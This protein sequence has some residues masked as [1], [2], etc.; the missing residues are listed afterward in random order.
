MDEITLLLI[1]ST[2]LLFYGLLA[3]RIDQ[4]GVSAP[5]L[6]TAVGILV[7]PLMLNLIDGSIDGEGLEYLSEL[8][9]AIILFTDAS[10]VN[11]HQLMKYGVLPIR[12]LAIGLPLTIVAGWL[13]AVPLLGLSWLAA[14]WLAVMLAPTDAALAQSI[15]SDRRISLKLRHTITVESGLNDGLALPVLLMILAL[16]SAGEYGFKSH[17]E[18]PLFMLQ[19]FVVGGLI[20]IGCGRWGGLLV[21]WASERN[22]MSEVYQRLS[23]ISL[24]LLA[25]SAAEQLGGNG[26]IAAFM[27]GLFLEAKRTVVVGRLREFG[28]AEG[29][30]L[31]LL[32]FFLFGLIFV[33]EALPLWNWQQLLYA[34]LSLTLVRMIPV[35]LCMA[36][37]GLPFGHKAFLAWFGPRGI[38]S[39][40]YLL[41]AIESMGYA[42]RISAYDDV[43]GTTVLTVLLSIVLHGVSTHIWKRWPK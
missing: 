3:K 6:M 39:I 24:A 8:A 21:Q 38:A 7:G 29:A 37:S 33:N 41:I 5:M 23:A 11:R 34:L 42:D 28:E 2:T 20:G 26:F 16:M 14:A 31:S 12:L 15:F 32:V 10:Q 4:T 9:L 27:A 17:T 13:L 22:N 25:Y 1:L 18:W 19:Q 36:G 30:L 35:M 43:F 40:L